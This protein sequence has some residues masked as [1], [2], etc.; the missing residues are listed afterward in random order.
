M[1][2]AFVDFCIQILANLAA[3]VLKWLLMNEF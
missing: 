2:Q 3:E 1:N